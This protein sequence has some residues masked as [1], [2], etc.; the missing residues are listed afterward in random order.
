[1]VVTHVANWYVGWGMILAAFVTGGGDRV[2]LSPRGFLGRVRVVSAA[3]R[4]PGAHRAGGAGDDQPALRDVALAAIGTG[5][6]LWAGRLWIVGGIAMPVVCFLC[7]L[8]RSVSPP[9]HHSGVALVGGGRPDVD[10]SQA[11]KIGFLAMSGVRAHDPK[12][13]ELGLTL[14]GFVE[15]SKTIA[16]LPSLGLLVSRRRARRRGTR[17][18]T[19]RPKRTAPSRPRSTRATWWRSAHSPRRSSR[20]TRSPTGCGARASR[21]RWA[22]CTSPSCRRRRRGTPTT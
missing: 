18:D 2:V 21:S 19:S 5:Q 10:R 7:G 14:P 9:V 11:M 16:S 6:G 17:C 3:D 20:R 12:L 15:R 8:A 4:A 1:M 22:G 13:L